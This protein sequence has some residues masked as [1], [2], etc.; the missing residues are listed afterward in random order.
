MQSS[1]HRWLSILCYRLR[2]KGRQK[3]I[4]AKWAGRRAESKIAGSGTCHIDD[5]EVPRPSESLFWHFFQPRV[6]G[7]AGWKERSW[8]QMANLSRI[9]L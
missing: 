5:G 3:T 1:G 2:D 4:S 8:G 9:A 6:V 7:C